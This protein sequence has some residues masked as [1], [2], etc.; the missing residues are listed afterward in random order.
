MNRISS[1]FFFQWKVPKSSCRSV[2]N[3]MKNFRAWWWFVEITLLFAFPFQPGSSWQSF[4][5]NT[6][7]VPSSRPSFNSWVSDREMSSNIWWNRGKDVKNWG[8]R[9]FLS[10]REEFSMKILFLRKGNCKEVLNN[11]WRIVIFTDFQ[12]SFQTFLLFKHTTMLWENKSVS[13]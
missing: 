11:G 8:W 6:V 10:S 2:G 5:L 3:W 1:N 13:Q 4:R 12:A 7:V 9:K